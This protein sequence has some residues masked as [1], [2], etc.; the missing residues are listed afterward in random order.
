MTTVEYKSR[1]KVTVPSKGSYCF[2]MVPDWEKPIAVNLKGNT[3]ECYEV[4]KSINDHKFFPLQEKL[5]RE[6]ECRRNDRYLSMFSS[7]LDHCKEPDKAMGVFNRLANI[8]MNIPYQDVYVDYG[9]RDHKVDFQI[10]LKSGIH[11]S[12]VKPISTEDDNLLAYTISYKQELVDAGCMD[13]DE[14][15]VKIREF[16]KETGWHV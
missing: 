3:S 13:I 10:L 12:V 7:F 8:L 9:H 5:Y 11:L 4:Y 14:F 15:G 6:V 16:V 1:T 2:F